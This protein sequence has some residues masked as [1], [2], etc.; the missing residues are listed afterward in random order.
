MQSNIIYDFEDY[1]ALLLDKAEEGAYYLPYDEIYFEKIGKNVV[2]TR[3][4]FAIFHRFVKNDEL[5]KYVDFKVEEDFTT[6]EI[7]HFIALARADRKILFT[8]FNP[9]KK[10]CFIL[11][12]SNDNDSKF[13]K[14][15]KQ[16]T[17]MG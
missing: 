6:K 16:L 10:E 13:M 12:V 15:I 9:N 17:E 4:V 5:T 8:I 1:R 7:A 11:F 14:A 3:E 2:I